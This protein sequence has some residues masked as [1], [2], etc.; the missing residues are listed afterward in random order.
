MLPNVTTVGTPDKPTVSVIIPTY[1]REKFVTKAI[2]SVLAQRFTDLEIIVVD[3]G[4]TDNTRDIL[5]PY[6]SKINYF[7]QDN[8]G[9][10]AARNTGI[11]ASKG[12]WIAFLDS[13][14]E[15]LPEYLDW[16]MERVRLCP[17]V[18][19]HISNS[20]T[21]LPN[22]A[23]E[24]HFKGTGLAAICK[25]NDCVTLERPLYAIIKHSPWFVQAVLMRRE[26]L[27]STSLFDRSLTIGED[28]DLIARMSLK[29]AFGIFNKQLV[30]IYR[31][32]EKLENLSAIVAKEGLYSYESLA[33]VFAQLKEVNNL[34]PKEQR[35]LDQALSANRRALA[36]LLLKSGRTKDARSQYRNALSL[37][38]SIKSVLRYLLSFL[39]ASIA[40]K[41][42][43]KGR[44]TQ[45]GRQKL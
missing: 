13:D 30:R 7:Y 26:V 39:P 35:I 6:F 16:Q 21:V 33:R 40:I 42:I 28:L 19:C 34:L 11:A 15:W 23:E 44:D 2:D 3:D 12:T 38:P 32:E 20:V 43:I 24:D 10:S 31:Q 45:L 36:N 14:D 1:N 18:I 5:K 27:L 17:S 25:K 9:V 4:S 29:G 8:H 37:N 22:K 41:S